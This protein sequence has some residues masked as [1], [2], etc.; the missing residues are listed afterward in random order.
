MAE[1]KSN[2][3]EVSCAAIDQGSL[4]PPQRVRPEFQWVE[5]NAG[6][7]FTDEAR[8][9]PGGEAV[10]V[11][12]ATREQELPR[13][14]S[15]Q[16][17]VVVNRLPGLFGDL[18]PDWAPGLPLSNSR[19]VEGVAIRRH[20]LYAYGDDVAAAQLTVDGEIEH[21]EVTCAPVELQFGPDGP[22]VALP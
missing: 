20:V 17:E 13:P 8:V 10:R 1:Q 9:L 22:D 15:F 12:T 18:E 2:G 4:G 6:D 5:T 21:C 3:P 16:L 11:A 14:P 7:P 19:P